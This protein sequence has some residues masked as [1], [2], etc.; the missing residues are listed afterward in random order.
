MFMAEGSIPSAMHR[1][2]RERER[3]RERER[4]KERERKR[5]GHVGN[6]YLH[7]KLSFTVGTW[8]LTRGKLLFT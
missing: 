7:R 3:V 5:E 8:C 2:W 4:K 6:Y 1:N